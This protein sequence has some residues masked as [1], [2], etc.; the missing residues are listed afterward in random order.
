MIEQ[1]RQEKERSLTVLLRHLGYEG[2]AQFR[3]EIV[4]RIVTIRIEAESY[5]GKSN[6]KPGEEGCV[7]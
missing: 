4:D 1:T 7:R 6:I 3:G 2:E 5:T